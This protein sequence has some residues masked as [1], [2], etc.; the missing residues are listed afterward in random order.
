MLSGNAYHRT[1]NRSTLNGDANDDFN[2]N[3]IVT[4]A[5]YVAPNS[6]A[7]PPIVGTQAIDQCDTSLDGRPHVKSNIL[8]NGT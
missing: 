7:T 5:N 4:S 3:L 1:S 8:N 2:D 6:S